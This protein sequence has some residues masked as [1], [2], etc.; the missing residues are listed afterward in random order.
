MKEWRKWSIEGIKIKISYSFFYF[1]SFFLVIGV[2]FFVFFIGWDGG[3]VLV[4]CLEGRFFDGLGFLV[5]EGVLV[6]CFLFMF[7]LCRFFGL[8]E[9]IRIC[10]FF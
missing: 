3:R 6:V 1:L 5:L 4:L 8:F 7:K 10:L 2:V 9:E